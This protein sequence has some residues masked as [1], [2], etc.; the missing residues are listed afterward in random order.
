[1]RARDDKKIPDY[2]SR[3]CFG[4]LD[5]YGNDGLQYE[6]GMTVAKHLKLTT[7]LFERACK[8]DAGSCF[9]LGILHQEGEGVSKDDAKAKELYA[10]TCSA[11]RGTGVS[12]L[13]CYL[14]T[15]LYGNASPAPPRNA[16][17][18]TVS[19]MKPQCEQMVAR[20]VASPASRSTRRAPAVR[21]EILKQGC[22]M[23]DAW[24]CDLQKRLK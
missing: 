7:S 13:F 4:T 24:A 20:P 6:F 23:K 9:R 8:L 5:A 12:K 22:E 2:S 18:H 3:A 21:C 1:M 17:E 19:I 11:P 10:R 14:N 15:K 16:L